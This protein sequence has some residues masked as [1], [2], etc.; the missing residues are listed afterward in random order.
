MNFKGNIS[1]S[2]DS[3]NNINIRL[4]D[5]VSRTEFVDVCMSLENY[6][7]LIT[8]LAEV[9]VVG[10]VRGLETVGKKRI[11]EQRSFV[12]TTE[13]TT[14]DFLEQYIKDNL[15]EEGWIVSPALRSQASIKYDGIGGHTVHYSVHKYV[16]VEE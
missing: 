16:D 11:I 9:E 13:N 15:Q 1:I 2:R 6:A 10:E 12:P 7:M 14:R 8:G 3:R 5:K 4:R